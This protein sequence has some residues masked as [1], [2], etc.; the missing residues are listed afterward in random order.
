VYRGGWRCQ[1]PKRRVPPTTSG[2]V[3]YYTILYM[4]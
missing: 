2:R 1:Q 3:V 4:L